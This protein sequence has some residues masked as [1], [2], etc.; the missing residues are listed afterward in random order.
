MIPLTLLLICLLVVLVVAPAATVRSIEDL[1]SWFS[2]FAVKSD[3]ASYCHLEIGLD[4]STIVTRNGSMMSI[5]DLAG[6][7]N[8][9]GHQE[10]DDIRARLAAAMA[11]SLGRPGHSIEVVFERDAGRTRSQIEASLRPSR[12]TATRIGLE[13]WNK[14]LD[15]YAD[16]LEQFSAA[17]SALLVVYTHPSLIPPEQ[18]KSE[19]K[20]K[21]E[22]AVKTRMPG[23]GSAQ[24][25]MAIVGALTHQ[26]QTMI[27]RIL[28]DISKAGLHAE[29]LESHVALRRIREAVDREWTSETWRPVLPGD[30]IP[31]RLVPRNGDAADLFAPKL[32]L[33]VA[34]RKA[35]IEGDLVKIGSRYTGTMVM[36]VGP[37]ETQSFMAL[38]RRLHVEIPYRVSISITPGG[39][40]Q[41]R[42]KKIMCSILGFLPGNKQIQSSFKALEAL[43]QQDVCLVGVRINLATWG[44][45][46]KVVRKNMTAI[47][48]AV[49]GWGGTDTTD[50]AGDPLSALASGLPGFSDTNIAPPLAM[51]LFDAISMLPV[52][53]PA[54]PWQEGPLIFGS[55]DGKLFPYEPGS[56]R[57]DAWVDLISA[58]MGS[59]KSVLLNILNRATCLRP[60]LTQLPLITIIDVAPSSRA[61]IDLL[62]ASL[63]P[64][65]HHEAAYYRLRM[66][67]EYA[68]NPFDTQLGC[69]YPNSMERAH[70]IGILSMLATPVGSTTPYESASDLAGLLIDEAYRVFGEEQPRRYERTVEPD[71]DQALDRI[72]HKVDS[73][74]TW[75]EVEDSLFAAGS[76][77]AASLAH[78]H[79]VPTLGDMMGMIQSDV[80]RDTFAR[81]ENSAVRISTGELLIDAMARVISAAMREYPVLATTTRFDLGLARVVSFDLDEVA[82]GGSEAGKKQAAIMYMMARH[83][84]AR[85]YYLDRNMIRS[86]KC[87]EQYL[88]YHDDRVDEIRAN[89]KTIRYD[90]FHRTGS[91]DALRDLISLD[92]REGRKWNIQITLVSQLLKDFTP[93][94]A[95]LATAIYILKADGAAMVEEA[96]LLFG[97]SDTAV[98]RLKADVH[99]PGK[100]G[101]NFLVRYKTKAGEIIQILTNLIGGMEIWATSTTSEDV[102]LRTQLAVLTGSPQR[103]WEILAAAYPG[104]SA[105]AEIE[106]RRKLLNSDEDANVIAAMARELASAALKEAA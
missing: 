46:P 52:Q 8:I 23:M 21:A 76:I 95:M 64:E 40:D 41:V 74:T 7:R 91:M 32:S 96:R 85:D 43:Q 87:P 33:Q 2:S 58:S 83:M 15:D 86:G 45:D 88:R 19:M 26:H 27:E 100:R 4:E 22:R 57:Q 84:A 5:L 72:N 17:E 38:F 44:D 9:V 12:E 10:F 73:A 3:I 39:L 11:P 37:Q 59:G 53:R 56:A 78:R 34:P 102:N 90:E 98:T 60:G 14:L 75:W 101:A 89:L 54:S 105:K 93:E 71:V 82:R 47:A 36:E 13:H 55:P 69:R 62:H 18:Y 80:I 61:L 97:L 50:D 103:A 51:P 65:R 92:I 28:D 20:D 68:V 49:Q 25:P 67:S 24:S 29:V 70:Q 42:F 81:S 104:G 30:K 66:D 35:V 106:S 77:H 31:L 6:C 16:K 79:A 94:M 1:M 99:G 63:P 48:K